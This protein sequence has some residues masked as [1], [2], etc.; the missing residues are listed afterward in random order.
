MWICQLSAYNIPLKNLTRLRSRADIHSD[1]I[2][3]G[4]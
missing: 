3:T 4:E 1:A 2:Q